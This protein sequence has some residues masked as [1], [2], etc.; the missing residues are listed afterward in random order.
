MESQN[1]RIR[2]RFKLRHGIVALLLL[3]FVLF[4]VTGSLKL[5]KQIE[6][7]RTK[8]YP[9]TLEELDRWYNIPEGAKNGADVYMNAFSN[10]IKWDKEALKALPVVGKAPLPARTQRLDASTR[11]LVEKF[12]SDNE[13]TLTLLH[14]AASIKHCRYPIDLTKG[15][16]D[17]MER[18]GLFASWYEDLRASAQLLRLETLS[19]CENQDPDKA[20]ES[21]RANF[22][23]ARFISAPLLIH[24]L[25]HNSVQSRTYK[26][27]ERI[28]NRIQLTE[29]QLMKLSSWIEEVGND[30]GYKRALIGENCI[31]L[32]AFRGHVKEVSDRLVSGG[33]LSIIFLAFLRVTGLNDRDATQY[34]DIM[35]ELIDAMELS[36]DDRLL[37]FDSIQKD[38]DSGIRGDMLTR[39]LMP[40]FGRIMQS[41]TRCTAHA[42]AAQTALAVERYRL[43]EGHLPESLE[44]LVPAYMEFIPKDPFDGRSLRYFTREN[45]F[46]VYSVGEDLT[47]EGGAERGRGRDAKGKPLPWDVTFIVER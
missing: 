43:A 24:R 9:V 35:Q 25:V 5:K 33:R 10:Y 28:L 29:E 34:I 44:N 7:L 26:S 22:A 30:E 13:K 31:G 38:V 3:L 41:D 2:R 37:V 8:G 19:H 21:I 17:L 46:V 1:R 36:A 47:D 42:L 23:L 39:M 6:I 15:P 45:G 18:P 40:A 4:R 32:H 27:I 14:E 20:L 12:L 16:V 11:K